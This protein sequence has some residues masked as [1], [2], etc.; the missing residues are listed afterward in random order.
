MKVKTALQRSKS[1]AR[2]LGIAAI[3]AALIVLYFRHWMAALVAGI[4][5]LALAA[6][7]INILNISRRSKS[8][9]AYLES[10]I[11]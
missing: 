3:V 5:F 2:F 8:D 1:N 4:V 11:E 9:P 6:E 7:A 10:R